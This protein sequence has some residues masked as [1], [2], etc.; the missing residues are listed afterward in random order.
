MNDTVCSPVIARLKA[1]RHVVMDMDG[2]IYSGSR[3]F[4]TTIP[5][6]RQL[7]AARIGYTFL[8]NNSSVGTADY[9]VK[10]H[11]MGIDVELDQIFTSTH[12]VIAYLRRRHPEIRKIFVLGTDSFKNELENAGF[13]ITFGEPDA[14]IMGF[15]TELEYRQ[16]CK[17][18]YWIRQGKPWFASHPD[19]ECPTDAQLVLVDCGAVIECLHSVTGRRP[20]KVLGKP[21][22]EM[23]DPIMQRYGLKKEEILMVGDR[24]NT[25]MELARNAGTP[26]V[27]IAAA[28][29]RIGG[30]ETILCAVR[31]LGELGALLNA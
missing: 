18:A 22:C 6:L 1:I 3:L 10:L 28:P 9:R 11:R 5:F 4:P 13:L 27:M 19:L 25:D 2:T 15:H 21:S 7:D 26:A 23:L 30:D 8:T 24:Y 14:V 12:S 17:T 31:N 20:D 16:L 29:D